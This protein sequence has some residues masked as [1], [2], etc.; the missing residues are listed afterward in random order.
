MEP[1]EI[2]FTLT[3][4]NF[5][6]G[7][8]GFEELMGECDLNAWHSADKFISSR[9]YNIRNEQILLK[10]DWKPA[11]QHVEYWADIASSQQKLNALL[12]KQLSKPKEIDPVKVNITVIMPTTLKDCSHI[13]ISYY[14]IH[15][16][17]EIFLILNLASPGCCNFGYST[18]ST[19]D[20]TWSE[21]FDLSP[22]TFESAWHDSLKIKWP[23]ITSIPLKLVFEWFNAL[24]IGTC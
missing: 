23:K 18:I 9:T 20:E 21:T 11:I 19:S 3:I 15:F 4:T 7:F 16:I 6:R 10:I 1:I 8:G 14:I 22:Y 13:E 17:H 12:N 5:G 24:N 2:T